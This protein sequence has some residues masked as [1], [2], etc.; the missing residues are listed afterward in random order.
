MPQAF[1]QNNMMFE[2][3]SSELH[4]HDTPGF[5]AFNFNALH[6]NI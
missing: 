6:H 4:R 3:M 1:R 2:M 5:H